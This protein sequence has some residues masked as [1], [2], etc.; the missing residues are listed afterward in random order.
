V[1]KGSYGL[2][3]TREQRPVKAPGQEEGKPKSRCPS[4][5]WPGRVSLFQGKNNPAGRRGRGYNRPA[6]GPPWGSPL[7]KV[8]RQRPMGKKEEKIWVQFCKPRKQNDKGTKGSKMKM[9][10]R[11]KGGAVT[12]CQGANMMVARCCTE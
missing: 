1:G 8:E 7:V 5:G 2:T 12:L 3:K 9:K 4:G 10:G 11:G 6:L